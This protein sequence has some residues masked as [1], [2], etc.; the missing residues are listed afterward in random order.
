MIKPGR[1]LASDTNNGVR[2][3]GP[4]V[5]RNTGVLDVYELAVVGAAPASNDA[6]W[7]VRCAVGVLA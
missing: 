5:D 7:G 2:S 1:H 6:T 4:G 3:R